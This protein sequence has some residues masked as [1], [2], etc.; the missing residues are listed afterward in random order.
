[1]ENADVDRFRKACAELGVK[2]VLIA[3][4]EE[5][6]GTFHHLMTSRT[7]R[8]PEQAALTQSITDAGM[9][10]VRGFDVVR[11]KIETTLTNPIANQPDRTFGYFESH[12][13]LKVP[14]VFMCVSKYEHQGWMDTLRNA[15]DEVNPYLKLSHN[16]FKIDYNEWTVSYFATLR[17]TRLDVNAHIF[18]KMVE[19]TVEGLSKKFRVGKVRTEFA[20]FDS[21]F[22]LD[23]GW[24]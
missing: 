3:M 7:Y 24:K 1:M 22:E 9:F 8:G 18:N 19:S 5:N 4:Q 11:S 23:K 20:W 10:L 16:P 12:V 14:H 6:G 15:V 21:N 13:E 17:E 2:P